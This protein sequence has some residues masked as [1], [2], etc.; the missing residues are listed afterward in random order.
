MTIGPISIFASAPIPS[1]YLWVLGGILL[2]ALVLL[3]ASTPRSTWKRP[4]A[5]MFFMGAGFLLLETKSVTEMSLLFGS[6]WHVNLLVFSSILLFI[7]M[8]NAVVDRYSPS[9]DR[10]F[11]GLFAALAVAYV[12]PVRSLLF[13]GELGQW[14]LGGA[15]VAVPIFFAGMIFASLLK[16]HTDS[17]RALAFNLLGAIL[18]GV[19]EYLHMIVGTKALYVVAGLIY[20]LAFWAYRRSARVNTAAD[21]ALATASLEAA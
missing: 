18:G 19:L 8:A 3:W 20:L 21:G 2:I 9:I 7:L 5:P 1:H 12:V 10:C 13:A 4:E 17:V 6:T 15:M 14:V 16:R 11:A